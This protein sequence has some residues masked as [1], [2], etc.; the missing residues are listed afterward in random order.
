[1]GRAPTHT[2]LLQ[3]KDKE[4]RRAK[5]GAGWANSWGGIS[6]VLDPGVVLSHRDCEDHYFNL[7]P[8]QDD[9]PPHTDEDQPEE[10]E[11]VN[12]PF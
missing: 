9:P 11:D 3:H 8:R 4:N 12:I 6:I 1:M 5:I 10:P 2:L 7:N